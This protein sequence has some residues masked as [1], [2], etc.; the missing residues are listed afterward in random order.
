MKPSIK[1]RLLGSV[2]VV[3]AT[4]VTIIYM[5]LIYQLEIHNDAEAQE[6]DDNNVTC[7]DF[8]V[9]LMIDPEI[10]SKF[11]NLQKGNRDEEEEINEEYRQYKELARQMFK[12][13]DDSPITFS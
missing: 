1:N 12:L 10:Y 7:T 5:R 8:S 11:E 13:R 4:F 6:Y 9:Q 2:V 3:T